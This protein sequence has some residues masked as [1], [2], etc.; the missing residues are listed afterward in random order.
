MKDNAQRCARTRIPEDNSVHP[1]DKAAEALD[2]AFERSQCTKMASREQA[3]ICHLS[4]AM[5]IHHRGF[6]APQLLLA[7]KALNAPKHS[8]L[9]LDT[10]AYDMSAIRT[11]AAAVLRETARIPRNKA[12]SNYTCQPLP[13]LEHRCCVYLLASTLHSLPSSRIPVFCFAFASCFFPHPHIL[14]SAIGHR[15]WAWN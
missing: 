10:C 14:A 4:L 9:L 8:R 3:V 12:V 15:L 2:H 11:L 13:G 6:R 1:V 5:V 7:K